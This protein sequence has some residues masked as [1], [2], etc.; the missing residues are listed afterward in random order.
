MTTTMMLLL[1]VIKAKMVMHVQL[2]RASLQHFA[3]KEIEDFDFKK[4]SSV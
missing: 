2:I 1:V 4:I 3:D